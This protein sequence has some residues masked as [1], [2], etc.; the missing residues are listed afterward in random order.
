MIA[1]RRLLIGSDIEEVIDANS[2][3]TAAGV[4]PLTLIGGPVQTSPSRA[5]CGRI[6][7][8][9]SHGA[10]RAELALGSSYALSRFGGAGDRAIAI[11]VLAAD[12]VDRAGRRACEQQKRD[13]YQDDQ[14][15]TAVCILITKPMHGPTASS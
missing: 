9:T 12:E 2:T 14:A 3:G 6:G 11:E 5:I 15:H 13:D 7:R 1:R 4:L 10:D 8:K